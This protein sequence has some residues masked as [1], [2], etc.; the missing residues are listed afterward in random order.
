M[1]QV[2]SVVVTVLP[3]SDM[4][5]DELSAF[6]VFVLTGGEVSA[7]SLPALVMQALS[8]AVAKFDGK[9]VA[10]GAIKRP[11]IGY[12]A[13]AFR[14][15]GATRDPVHF[16]FELGWIYVHPSARGKGIASSLV[17]ALVPSLKGAPAYATS[18]VNNVRM[19]AALKRVDFKAVGTPY[20]SGLSESDIQLF[21]CE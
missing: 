16:A 10:V 18:R 5:A 1:S 14:K 9:L 17:E 19:H 3:P 21:L 20:P 11:N 2:P 8:L 15:S 4:S 7:E 12:R 6:K 13:R